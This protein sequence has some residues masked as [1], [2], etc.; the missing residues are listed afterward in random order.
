M[1]L[2]LLD[3]IVRSNRLQVIGPITREGG[4]IY[5]D[6]ARLRATRTVRQPGNSPDDC[7]GCS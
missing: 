1:P 4:G 5:I 6:G 2:T 3:S 7:L